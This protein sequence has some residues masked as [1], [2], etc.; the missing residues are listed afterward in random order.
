MELLLPRN[1]TDRWNKGKSDVEVAGT[2]VMPRG[3]EVG[4]HGI[5]IVDFRTTSLIGDTP[6]RMIRASARKLNNDIPRVAEKY[7]DRLQKNIYQH[8]IIERTIEAHCSTTDNEILRERL[9]VIDAESKQYMVH[10]EKKCRRLKSGLIQFS[11][12]SAI[13]IRRCQVYRSLLRYHAKDIRNRGNLKCAARLIAP[14]TRLV[15]RRSN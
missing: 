5:F 3:C 2:C 4:D 9:E 6:P 7:T 14:T 1:Y 8:R 15:S 11:P 13:W 10:A 12:D